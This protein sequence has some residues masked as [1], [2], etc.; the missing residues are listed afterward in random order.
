[1][2]SDA[3]HTKLND[4]TRWSVLAF[5]RNAAGEHAD[6]LNN[7]RKAAEA[8]CKVLLH[9]ALP[10]ARAEEAIS[11]ADLHQLIGAV[12]RMADVPPEVL[13][14]LIALRIHGNKGVHDGNEARGPAAI[15]AV[16]LGALAEWLHVARLGAAL[17]RE[18]ADAMGGKAARTRMKEEQRRQEAEQQAL[19]ARIGGLQQ[20]IDAIA[21]REAREHDEREALERELAAVRKAAEEKD[22]LRDELARLR[23]AVE[24]Q[25]TVAAPTLPIP[26]DRSPRRT[27]WW[28]AAAVLMI[29]AVAALW[30]SRADGGAA[31]AAEDWAAPPDTVLRVAITPFTVMQDDPN[32]QLRFEEVLRTALRERADGLR[33]AVDLRVLDDAPARALSSE[34]ALAL[35]DSLHAGLLIHGE[36]AEPSSADSGAV[37]LRFVMRRQRDM[38][39]DFFRPLAFRTLRDPGIT[40]VISAVSSMM[41]R[42]MANVHAR[43]GDRSRALA[44]LYAAEPVSKEDR[45]MRTLFRAQCHTELGQHKE[46]LRA[47]LELNAMQPDEP[48][49]YMLAAKCLRA[50]GRYEEATNAYEV[51]VTKRPN[52]PVLLL[53]LA[54][55][56]VATGGDDPQVLRRGETLVRRALELDSSSAR[57]W[58]YLGQAD[59]TAQ[60]WADARTHLGKAIALGATEAPART[61]LAEILF[62]RQKQPDVAQAEQLLL[63]VFAA[64]ST[65][66]KALY[67]L[68]ELYAKSSKRDPVK[69]K[70]FYERAERRSPQAEREN[71]LGLATVAIQQGRADEAIN[72]L[73]PLWTRDSS[74]REMGN[75]LA[76]AYLETGRHAEALAVA[77]T[78][79]R[80]DPLDKLS[81][82]NVG[83]I[84]RFGS[85]DVYD[86]PLAAKHFKEALRTD[87]QDT[88]VLG[89]L[90]NT[91][92]EL[93]DLPGAEFYLKRGIAL[94]PNDYGLNRGMA[95]LLDQT[96][97]NSEAFA[98]YERAVQARPDDPLMLS[99]LAYFCLAQGPHKD[100]A[101]ALRLAEESVR[102]D[103]IPPNRMVLSMALLMNKRYAEASTIYRAAVAEQPEVATPEV[104]AEL[105]KHGY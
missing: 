50:L 82:Y 101:K 58:F 46:A 33:M 69:A 30:W 38:E 86:L 77:R 56:L 105:R 80:I 76:Q 74:H 104:E 9:H 31:A 10:R 83:Y 18:L 23:S 1:M 84:H 95:L 93:H 22:A 68:G 7:M 103:P 90:G 78:M 65:E 4:F 19:D 43:R 45:W 57:G 48:F 34:E 28:L 81:H 47:S 6:A 96:G 99:N 85:A 92:L 98:Y 102:I 20:R 89:Y 88:L 25:R 42:A 41:D 72:L 12:Q 21:A 49:P 75:T 53:D 59:Y 79:L 100:Y 87:P 35:A 24:E 73:A 11:G 61:N 13:N 66:P 16:H 8:A 27:R 91:L 15:G 97:R 70:L 64:D 44:L 29:G 67:L 51:A 37:T 40:Q 17:P 39:Q 32:L 36:L 62:L 94:A 60:R 14:H 2:P 55:I 5:E 52:D 54:D 26:Q 63:E 3:L 71:K